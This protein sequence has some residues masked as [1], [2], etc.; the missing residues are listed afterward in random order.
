MY[1]GITKLFHPLRARKTLR[2]HASR[3]FT[4]KFLQYCDTLWADKSWK[5]YI[6]LNSLC[7][8]FFVSFSQKSYSMI[9]SRIVYMKCGSARLTCGFI[10]L[11][12]HIYRAIVYLKTPSKLPRP[13]CRFRHRDA[14]I[15]L[16][17]PFHLL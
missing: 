8:M 7:Y 11:S 14:T 3:L 17:H 15:S 4:R 16:L 9:T 6:Y 13:S 1:I 5:C 10:L 12:K 2:F